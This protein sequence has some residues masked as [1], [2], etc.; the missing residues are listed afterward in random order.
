V[1]QKL[2]IEGF[3]RGLVSVQEREGWP[4]NVWAVTE[5]GVALEAQLDGKGTYHGYPMQHSDALREEILRR[6]F[7]R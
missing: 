5:S 7:T 2:L 1:A 4:Q 3:R 6:W